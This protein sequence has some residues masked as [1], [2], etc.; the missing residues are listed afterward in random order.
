[1]I[2]EKY[3]KCVIV[4]LIFSVLF[5]FFDSFFTLPGWVNGSPR[6]IDGNYVL[7]NKGT[8]SKITEQEYHRFKCLEQQNEAAH[9]MTGY[10]I[11][12][13]IRCEKDKGYSEKEKVSQ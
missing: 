13:F 4:I 8:I 5:S 12:M 10:A 1:M 9:M 6:I 11:V 3:F 7:Q 2:P